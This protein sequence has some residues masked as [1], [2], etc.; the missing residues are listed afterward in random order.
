M[1]LKKENVFTIIDHG[2]KQ[3]SGGGEPKKDF[4][5]SRDNSP[6]GDCKHSRTK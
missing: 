6:G 1:S 2:G 4:G 3:N 5:T